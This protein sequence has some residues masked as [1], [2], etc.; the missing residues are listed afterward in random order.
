[1]PDLAVCTITGV[2]RNHDGTPMA[3]GKIR[4]HKV[5]MTGAAIEHANN[6][7]GYSTTSEADGVMT[8]EL[9]RGSTAYLSGPFTINGVD[10]S[11]GRSPNGRAVTVPDAATADLEDLPTPSQ[12]PSQGL[13]VEADDAPLSGLFGILNFSPAF[14][15]ERNGLQADIDLADNPFPDYLTQVEADARYELAGAGGGA[16][17]GITG[18]IADQIDLQAALDLK[19]PLLSPALTG[20]PTA[21]T[22]LAG[23]NT[24]QLAT[25]AFVQAGL[26]T[27]DLSSKQDADS[28]LTAI[29]G[30]SPSNDDI[31]Q[32]KAGAWTNRSPAQLKTDL[33]I[34]AGDVSGLSAAIDARITNS[35][36][37]SAIGYTPQQQDAELTALAALTSAA[38]K[39]PYFTGSGAASLFDLT[40]FARTLLDDANQGAMQTTLGLVPGTNVQAFNVNLAALAGLTLAADKL[41][42]ATGAGAL[43]L[44]DLSSFART[45]LDDTTQAAAQ[46]TLGLGTGDSPAFT[47]LTVPTVYGSAASGGNLT[48]HSTQHATKGK[49][50]FG[51][52]AAYDGV[53]TRLGVGTQSPLTKLHVSDGNAPAAALYSSSDYQTVSGQ[54][55]PVGLNLIAVTSADAFGRAVFKG[56]RARNTLGSPTAAADGDYTFSLLGAAYDGTSTN[57]TA[58]VSFVVEGAVGAGVTPQAIILETGATNSRTE[59]VRI[60]PA[61]LVR[62]GSSGTPAAQLHVVAASG[63]KA[64]I[65]E[66]AS[67][68]N[69]VEVYG[70]GHRVS[71]T[72]YVRVA[73]SNALTGLT[74][75]CEGAGT[76]G[77]TNANQDVTLTPRGSGAVK[78]AAKVLATAG[79]GVG[80]SAA[81]TTLGSVTKKI[82]V[83]DA[84]GA[85]L[86]YLPVYDAI[87]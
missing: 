23:T 82:Q 62:V 80:N 86:G 27:V 57:A 29:A 28:D 78:T 37:L 83:F 66:A 15:V 45:L 61:G 11:Q 77:T 30:L 1:M 35:A 40:S 44:T 75:A 71:S 69:A 16:W 67:S 17:G 72:D 38:D 2:A 49:I 59:R 52:G 64:L 6:S 46:T 51:T 26:A 41:P 31:L 56:T 87:T 53:N 25:T 43:A 32:R 18:D 74:I 4:V 36:V 76:T 60:N 14:S 8:L 68:Q 3:G 22:A 81:A 85:S 21:P 33:A 73:I 7:I 42:Y 10:F 47:A 84:A 5:L 20:T 65:V 79:L 9:P 50:L 12:V 55:G 63:N 13:T 48:L 24:T 70:N 54:G 34:A 58:G 39:A 19:A